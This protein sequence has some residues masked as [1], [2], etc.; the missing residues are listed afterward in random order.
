MTSLLLFSADGQMVEREVPIGGDEIS[1][2]RDPNNALIV[3]DLGVSRRHARVL[4]TSR[5]YLLVDAESESGVWIGERR[6]RHHFL[7]AGDVFRIGDRLIQFCDPDSPTAIDGL[8]PAA[9]PA[10]PSSVTSPAP[11]A[12]PALAEL[13]PLPVVQEPTVLELGSALVELEPTFVDLAPPETPDAPTAPQPAAPQPQRAPSALWV[14]SILLLSAGACAA[15]LALYASRR[16]WV[17]WLTGTF[18]RGTTREAASPVAPELADFGRLARV[19]ARQMLALG[20]RGS[21]H[22]L[23]ASARLVVPEAALADRLSLDV[24]VVELDLHRVARE[25]RD[26]HAYVLDAASGTPLAQ[27]IVLEVAW[28]SAQTS[29]AEHEAGGWRTL[30]LAQGPSVRVPID[31]FSRRTFAVV[32]W[33]DSPPVLP[34][35]DAYPLPDGSEQSAPTPRRLL[36]DPSYRKFIGAEPGQRRGDRAALCAELAARL[37]LH[38]GLSFARP[39]LGVKEVPAPEP[40]LPAGNPFEALVSSPDDPRSQDRNVYVRLTNDPP[41]DGDPRSREQRLEDAIIASPGALRPAD[42]MEM[43]LQAC[44]GNYGSPALPVGCHDRPG[45]GG[46]NPPRASRTIAMSG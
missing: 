27:P 23:G 7:A 45:N 25:V 38:P 19:S 8:G 26:A 44:A 1:I 33:N 43:A 29:V 39:R 2:G 16:S 36:E 32:E 10:S 20:S 11:V 4:A 24:A 30:P 40:G 28:P 46:H 37:L 5:G 9:A 31:R 6:V 41:G 12:D 34:V 15:G 13:H 35:A 17:P 22:P 18:E 14:A 42:V 21:Q 3:P